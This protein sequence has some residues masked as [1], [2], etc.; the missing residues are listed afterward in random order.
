MSLSSRIT[1]LRTDLGMSQNQLAKLMDVSRQAVS[2]WENGLS[3]PDPAKMLLLAEVLKTD[4]VYLTTGDRQ[5]QKEVIEKIVEIPVEVPIIQY[6]DRVTV[7]R[8]VRKQYRRHPV[9]YLI[10]VL[11]GIIIGFLIG[12]ML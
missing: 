9:E 5:V 11:L 1:Q 4:L 3:T 10:M 6:V 2:K 7:K 8:I 12:R